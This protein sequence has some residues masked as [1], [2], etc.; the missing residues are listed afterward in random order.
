[1]FCN[2]EE[3][4]VDGICQAGLD[5]CPGLTCDEEADVCATCLDDAECDDSLFCNGEESCT[6]GE[7]QP[8]TDPCQGQVCDEEA[9]SCTACVEDAD[10]SDGDACNG[11]ETCEQ[12]ECRPGNP[13]CDDG[14]DCTEDE[15]QVGGGCTHLP[16]DDLCDDGD[17]CTLDSCDREAGC[18]HQFIDTDGDGRCDA[19]DPCPADD[20]DFCEQFDNGKV[21]GGGCGCG[22]PGGSRMPALVLTGL[23]L[24]C[25]LRRR[26]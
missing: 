1:L 15:C 6:D 25:L 10:C 22:V 13:L 3:R 2:G 16:D 17:P 18:D 9:D 8:G 14:L 7:C 26:R 5:P 20:E 11:E 4:C 23:V 12:G 24:L 19:E 21:A